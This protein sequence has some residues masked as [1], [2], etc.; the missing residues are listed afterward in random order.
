MRRKVCRF[1]RRHSQHLLVGVP[2]LA[3]ATLSTAALFYMQ[4]T[5]TNTTS[6]TTTST[7]TAASAATRHS[8]DT[9]LLDQ[10]QMMMTLLEE[11]DHHDHQQGHQS[12]ED[13]SG[14]DGSDDD[15][16]D[17][18]SGGIE[19]SSISSSIMTET[20]AIR[21]LFPP[22][23]QA[24][25]RHTRH[26]QHDHDTSPSSSPPPLSPIAEPLTKLQLAIRK[27]VLCVYSVCLSF[28]A[29]KVQVGQVVTDT[30]VA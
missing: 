23:L 27:T 6:T 22:L 16:R 19:G 28:I 4:D 15:D 14:G 11:A 25:V 5:A 17:S 24:I 2:V 12:T 20:D 30:A 29:A 1:V 9:L 8:D 21:V 7:T 13:G 26:H 10:D 3:I 18:D